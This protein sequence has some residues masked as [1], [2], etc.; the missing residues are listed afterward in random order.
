MEGIEL[1]TVPIVSQFWCYGLYL[2]LTFIITRNLEWARLQFY[3]GNWITLMA[4][5]LFFFCISRFLG[6]HVSISKYFFASVVA[7]WHLPRKN[8]RSWQGSVCVPPY[9]S[10]TWCL[11]QTQTQCCELRWQRRIYMWKE[12]R[13]LWSF[14]Q[15]EED[16]M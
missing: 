6:V 3:R 2:Y 7:G 15:D 4:Q 11:M 8:T 16:F 9:V 12:V 1:A 10:R 13:F 14:H 5:S